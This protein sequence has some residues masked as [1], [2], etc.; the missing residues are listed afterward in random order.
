[1]PQKT[2]YRNLLL[3]L[4]AGVLF[5][6]AFATAAVQGTGDRP[7]PTVA[8]LVVPHTQILPNG[9]VAHPAFS[10]ARD[11]VHQLSMSVNQRMVGGAA[12]PSSGGYWLV[13]A[14]GG[15]F[16]FG[17][18]VFQGS[19]G[20]MRLARP[21]VG[22]AATP[23]GRGY[24]LVA[25]DGGIFSFGDAV[26]HGSTGGLQLAR[27]VVGMAATPS[28]QGYWLV[29]SDGGIFSFGD[30]V[31]HGSTG[32]LQLARPVVGIAASPTGH[33][34]WLVA[35]DGGVFTFG[36]AAFHGSTAGGPSAV[37]IASAGTGQGYWLVAPD[38]GVTGFGDATNIGS[39]SNMLT[40]SATSAAALP[41]G[42]G[43]VVVGSDGSSVTLTPG[44]ASAASVPAVPAGNTGSFSYLATNPDGSPARYDPCTPIHYVTN[45]AQGPANAAA[46]VQMALAQVSTATG[47]QFVDDGPTT[48]VPDANRPLY[49]Q[50][51]ASPAWAPVLIAWTTPAQSNLLQG[52]SS[53]V[54][55][56]GSW[57]VTAG[58]GNEVYVTGEV[59]M[60][61]SRANNLINGFG[62]GSEGQLLLHEL[63]HVVGLGHTQDPMQI[64]YPTIL[65]THT[66]GYQAGDRAGLAHLGTGAGC[67]LP[68]SP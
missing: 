39:A 55:E 49:A 42:H 12:T 3:T 28:G 65:P 27:P 9:V 41:A 17:D 8:S 38:G 51:G 30:A 67:L 2:S 52:A 7:A 22:M 11:A 45:V 24:W 13:A 34:Y 20:A 37:S 64:M 63:G 16:S 18:A 59:A 14:D 40:A 54:G 47:I 6:A 4:G 56:G 29:A 1:M 48:E 15:I 66:S 60:N 57:W 10:E 23:T 5:G 35:S 62:G 46:L 61:A 36:D 58:S 26:F 43:V 68:P 21:I 31:F 44:G 53:I 19:T 25:S 32:G 33:G 50:G